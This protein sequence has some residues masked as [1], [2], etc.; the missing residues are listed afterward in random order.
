MSD[1]PNVTAPILQVVPRLEVSDVASAHAPFLYIDGAPA[2][3]YNTGIIGV[4]LEAIRLMTGE[5]QPRQERVVVAHLRMS[6]PAAQA[7]KAAIDGALFAA[8]PTAGGGDQ[9]PN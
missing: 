2:W 6:I 9:K 8:M 1:Q 5:Q 7:L 4:T 3:A